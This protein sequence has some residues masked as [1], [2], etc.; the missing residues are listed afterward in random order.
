MRPRA[1]AR[2]R[3]T[4]SSPGT[5]RARPIPT[6]S[7]SIPSLSHLPADYD[8]VVYGPEDDVVASAMRRTAMRRTA[9]RRTPVEDDGEE[10]LDES[11]IAP[12]QLQDIAMRRTGLA[13]RATSIQR[14]TTD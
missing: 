2:S 14:G 11:S 8:I 9:M 6:S 12:D 5:S 1:R 3:P 10:P 4:S 7:R 13:V